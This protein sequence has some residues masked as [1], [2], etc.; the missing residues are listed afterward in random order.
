MNTASQ[1]M[2]KI[3]IHGDITP[4]LLFWNVAPSQKK[5]IFYFEYFYV[6]SL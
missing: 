4:L 2:V 3:G 1:I 6:D 5:N